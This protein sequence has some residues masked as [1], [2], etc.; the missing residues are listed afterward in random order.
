MLWSVCFAAYCYENMLAVCFFVSIKRLR[1]FILGKKEL[2][3]DPSCYDLNKPLVGIEEIRKFNKQRFDMEQLTAVVYENSA[4]VACVGYKD[5]T[6]DE[7]W[8]SGHM[9]GYALMPGVIMCEVAAQLAS[10]YSLSNKLMDE[11]TTMGFAGLDKVRFR[12]MVRPGDRLVMQTK[13]ITLRKIL[14]TARFLGLVNDEIVCEGIIKGVPLQL[15][16]EI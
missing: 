6:K 4:D 15:D 9:P 7:F 5:I 13:M 2:L 3:V 11:S 16:I 14:I 8:I 1:S 12:G 10:Y